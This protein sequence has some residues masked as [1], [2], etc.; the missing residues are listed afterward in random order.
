MPTTLVFF[1]GVCGLCDGFVQFLLKRDRQGQ[2]RFATLQGDL[3]RGML[4][5]QGYDPADLDSVIVVTDWK[6]PSQ[7]V[8]AGSSAVLH[9]VRMLGGGWGVLAI[10][11]RLVPTVVADAT[12]RLVARW[13]YRIFGRF[14]VCPLPR[15][16]WRDRFIE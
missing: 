10:A 16:E 5:A 6:G 14:D 15:P 8:L 1:D 11:G 4:P 13:R 7:R 9:S 12:Y 3:A 2:F